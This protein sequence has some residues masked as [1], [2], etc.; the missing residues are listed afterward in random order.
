MP[1]EYTL[2]LEVFHDKIPD[3]SMTSHEFN[4]LFGSLSYLRIK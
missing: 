2:E 3:G 4:N 1:D